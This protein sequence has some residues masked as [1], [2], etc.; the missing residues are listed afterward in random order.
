MPSSTYTPLQT[1]TLSSAASSITFSSIPATYRDLILVGDGQTTDGSESN[2]NVRF[3]SDSGSNYSFVRMFGGSSVSSSSGTVSELRFVLG[4]S[5][6]AGNN[7]SQIMDYSAT[8][9]HK[10]ILSRANAMSQS[11]V[12]ARATRW[13]NTDAIHTITIEARAGSM[14]VGTTLS[15]YGIAG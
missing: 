5:S 12:G 13:A 14:A 1:I 4:T 10:T 8:D 9:K 7:I 6:Q 3:N 2:F 15:L 11:Y